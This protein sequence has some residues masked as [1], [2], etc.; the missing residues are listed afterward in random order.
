MKKFFLAAFRRSDIRN[1]RIIYSGA[2]A[3]AFIYDN[4]SGSTFTN[5]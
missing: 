2:G 4:D 3:D 1:E 5:K